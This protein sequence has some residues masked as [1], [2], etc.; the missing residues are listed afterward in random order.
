MISCSGIQM[1]P[2]VQHLVRGGGQNEWESGTNERAS[3]L[4]F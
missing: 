2:D 3:T 4:V 1:G